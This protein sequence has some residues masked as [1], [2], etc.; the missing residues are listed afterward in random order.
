[1]LYYPRIKVTLEICW[2]NPEG[3]PAPTRLSVLSG[4]RNGKGNEG[5]DDEEEDLHC[6]S[7]VR[8]VT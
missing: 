5:C 7:W 6:G 1:M 2:V 4:C 3:C 8:C